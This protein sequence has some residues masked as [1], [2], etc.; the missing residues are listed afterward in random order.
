MEGLYSNLL[1]LKNVSKTYTT[2]GGFS[3]AINVNN[4]VTI[5]PIEYKSNN[6]IEYVYVIKLTNNENI[7]VHKPSEDYYKIDILFNK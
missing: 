1:F 3:I 5:Q 2:K 7:C 6:W 4:I